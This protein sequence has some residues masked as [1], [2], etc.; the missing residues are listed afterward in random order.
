M[1]SK[2]NP[3][4]QASCVLRI[5]S[6]YSK[7]CRLVSEDML[8]FY[9]RSFNVY[10]TFF[11]SAV[12]IILLLPTCVNERVICWIHGTV[13]LPIDGV[14]GEATLYLGV[15]QKPKS[16]DLIKTSPYMHSL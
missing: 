9:R 15:H 14:R 3:E 16:V 7:S 8:R 2:M 4:L 1:A 13:T 11:V 12:T 10:S 5:H 6:N